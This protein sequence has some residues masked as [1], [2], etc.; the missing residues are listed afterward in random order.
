MWSNDNKEIAN[1]H[2]IEQGQDKNS[3]VNN[4]ISGEKQRM[5]PKGGKVR[6]EDVNN[7][8]QWALRQ[9]HS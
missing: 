5:S 2:N 6:C 1:L 4:R 3:K 9:A 7:F 8:S